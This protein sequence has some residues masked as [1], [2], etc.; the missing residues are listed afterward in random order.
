MIGK[1]EYDNGLRC[2]G[3]CTFCKQK[4]VCYQGIILNSNQHTTHKDKYPTIDKVYLLDNNV[5]IGV[6]QSTV[7]DKTCLCFARLVK[8]K[9][10]TE[11][12]EFIEKQEDMDKYINRNMERWI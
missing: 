1:Q 3:I 8:G 2:K 7:E 12:F 5:M 10:H 11:R 6:D 9:F 4:D